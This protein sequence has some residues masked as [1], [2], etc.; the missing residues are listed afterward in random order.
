MESRCGPRS[1]RRNRI[2]LWGSLHEI[3]YLHQVVYGG[4]EGEQPADPSHATEFDLLQQPH[5]FQL[6]ENLFDPFAL[7]LTDSEPGCR[8]VRPSIEMARFVVCW[9]TWG[10]T[11]N[12]RRSWELVGVVV[13]IPPSV[14]RRVGG[15]LSFD[16]AS[17]ESPTFRVLAL[18]LTGFAPGKFVDFFLIYPLFHHRALDGT[19]LELSCFEQTATSPQ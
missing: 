19:R 8:I 18:L 7:L 17:V 5:C 14:I 12:P 1:A 3:A 2:G 9:A 15:R 10:V 4:S 11:C 6:A 16:M 13:H